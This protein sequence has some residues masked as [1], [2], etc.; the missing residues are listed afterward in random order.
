VK[1][2]ATI[3]SVFVIWRILLGWLFVG[4]LGYPCRDDG[5]CDHPTLTCER[6][7]APVWLCALKEAKP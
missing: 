6:V 3:I 1:H 4:E 7:A 2:I 5:S